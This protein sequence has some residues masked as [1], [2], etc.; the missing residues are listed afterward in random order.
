MTEPDHP[1]PPG[2]TIQELLE[3][4]NINPHT[5]ADRCGLT[6]KELQHLLAGHTALTP[7]LAE[8]IGQQLKLEPRILLNLEKRYTQTLQKLGKTHNKYGKTT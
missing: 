4:Q 6:H 1:I 5:F 3:N 7:P 8:Q 2:E